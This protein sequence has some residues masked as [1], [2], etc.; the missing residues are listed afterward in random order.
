LDVYHPA[1]SEKNILKY[2]RTAE[3]EKLYITGG[4]DWHGE[5][6]HRDTT[7]FGVCGLKDNNYEILKVGD[8][9]KSK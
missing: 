7:Y 1:H 6:N 5:N 2:L 4:T 3:K 9:F 8:R